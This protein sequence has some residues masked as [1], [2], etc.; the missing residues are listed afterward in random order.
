MMNEKKLKITIGLLII[1]PL[2]A[3][4]SSSGEPYNYYNQ[5]KGSEK[6]RRKGTS[7][8]YTEEYERAREGRQQAGSNYYYP[9]QYDKSQSNETRT[10]TNYY[11][12][13]DD[14]EFKIDE[15]PLKIR[16]Y[17]QDL[18]EDGILDI[19]TMCLGTSCYDYNQLGELVGVREVKGDSPEEDK[20]I[21]L[22]D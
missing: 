8:Y 12:D 1:L 5:Y 4:L 16:K 14:G 17:Y 7:Y 13:V 9:E 3:P 15:E 6:E 10:G 22:N 18:N 11:Y 21:E 20:Q 2:L 19:F